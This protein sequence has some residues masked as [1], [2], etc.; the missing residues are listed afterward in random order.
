MDEY[1]GKM[2]A[3][4]YLDETASDLQRTALAAIF[5]AL[6]GAMFGSM[7]GPKAASIEYLRQKDNFS[8]KIPGTL[9]AAVEPLTGADG[10]TP[11]ILHAPMGFA[12][13]LQVAVSL[14]HKYE[15]AD[16]DSW[17]YEAG[18]NGFFADFEFTSGS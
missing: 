10:K 3:V 4:M 14:R 9:D 6:F 18:R 13:E 2:K 16:L 1:M 11:R 8:V 7:A 17:D 12:D 15:G 5:G